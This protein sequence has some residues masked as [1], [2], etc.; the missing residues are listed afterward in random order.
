MGLRGAV[1][2]S[3]ALKNNSGSPP[4]CRSVDQW[5][6]RTLEEVLG[7][8]RGSLIIL[9]IFVAFYHVISQVGVVVISLEYVHGGIVFTVNLV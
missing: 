1:S 8:A 4:K 2:M 7:R 3:F 6:K 5:S 9:A